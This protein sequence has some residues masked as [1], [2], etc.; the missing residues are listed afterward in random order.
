MGLLSHNSIKDGP[1]HRTVGSNPTS[2]PH[3]R[4]FGRWLTNG[5][6]FHVGATNP[7]F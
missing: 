7:A 2:I 4:A 6:A 1:T 5:R 3:A